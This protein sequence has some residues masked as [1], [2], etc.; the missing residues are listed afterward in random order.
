MIKFNIDEAFIDVAHYLADEGIALIWEPRFTE[1]K[2]T[3]ELLNQTSTIPVENDTP[4]LYLSIK[5]DQY[6]EDSNECCVTVSRSE[7]TIEDD[8]SISH[9]DRFNLVGSKGSMDAE[10]FEDTVLTAFD[11]LDLDCNVE[12]KN[13]SFNFHFYCN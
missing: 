9:L 10:A 2:E 11:Q 7:F 1:G 13:D 4:Y 12:R 5:E 3:N 6:D 8:W